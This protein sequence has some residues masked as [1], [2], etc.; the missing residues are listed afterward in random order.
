MQKSL[1]IL[2]AVALMALFAS[3]T[4]ENS[5]E[6]GSGKANIYTWRFVEGGQEYSGIM[7]TAYVEEVTGIKVLSAEGVSNDGMDNIMLAVG[8]LNDI[9]PGTYT[10]PE[11][12]FNYLNNGNIKYEVDMSRMNFSIIITSINSESVSGTFSGTVFGEDGSDRE[13]TEGT[14]TAPL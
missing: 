12:L 3:C 4:K 8:A 14:F 1:P 10:S 6:E 11:A 13:I 9:Q 2:L 5:F 7:D